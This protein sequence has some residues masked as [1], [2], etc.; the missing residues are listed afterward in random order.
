MSAVI[1]LLTFIVLFI[2]LGAVLIRSRQMH[3]W[4]RDYL[5]FA[6][7]SKF[8]SRPL[9]EVYFAFVDHYEPYWNGA[10]K[11]LARERVKAWFN[12]YPSIAQHH[13]D[14]AGNNPC[15]TFFYPEEEYDPEVLEMLAGIVSK[16]VADVDIHLHHDNDTAVELT[17][18]LLDFKVI[19]H[20]KHGLL[21]TNSNGEIIYGFI[22]GNWAL[23]NSRADGRM[24]GVDNEIEVLMKTGCYADFTMPS[25]PSETQS[26]QVNS[27]YYAVQKPGPKS[28]D[29]GT[30]VTVGHQPPD[31]ALLMVQGV[32][33][34][35]WRDRKFGILPRIET[36]EIAHD[37]KMTPERLK[38]WFQL[39]PRIRGAEEIGFVKIFTHGAQDKNMSLLLNGELD[40][41]WSFLE[42][43]CRNNNI[44]LHY[45]S[46]YT[47]YQ[48]IKDLEKID[49]HGKLFPGQ[50]NR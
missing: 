40:K 14:V 4:I 8:R 19:L 39:C 5:T 18:K 45:V 47:M 48:K 44:R 13:A 7:T 46:A 26:A 21:R 6:I 33:G 10:S 38:L 37:K 42:E 30:D 22:H 41:I 15:H 2:V 3:Y 16:G 32:L 49:P 23:C 29:R 20:E 17:K 31:E 11:E 27:L 35:N 24:C 25:A 12:A 43:H 36:G 34:L 1:M 9:T 50:D 28:Y